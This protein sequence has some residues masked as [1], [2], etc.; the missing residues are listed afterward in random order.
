MSDADLAA[1]M[2]SIM[3]GQYSY[4]SQARAA[5]MLEHVLASQGA[6]LQNLGL[7]HIVCT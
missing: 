7:G 4:E 2:N 5:V 6:R 3:N 1:R